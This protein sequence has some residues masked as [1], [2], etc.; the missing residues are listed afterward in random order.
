M[1]NHNTDEEEPADRAAE[2]TAKL[3]DVAAE[4]GLCRVHVLAWRD[5]DDAEAG[6]SEVHADRIASLWAEAG[7]DVLLRTSRAEGLAR[8]AARGGYRVAR[9]G[10]RLAA[11]PDAVIQE[12]LGRDG[13]R[14]AL[15]EVWNGMPYFSPLWARGPRVTFVHHVHAEMWRQALTP[16][17]ARLG[18]TIELRIAPRLYRGTRVLTGSASA[19]QTILDQ[20]GLAPDRVSIVPY[21]IGDGFSAAGP[22]SPTPLV[23]VAGRLVPHK[24]I[25]T[26][27]RTVVRLR[28]RHPDLELVVV[29]EGW[30]RPA[31]EAL[32]DELAA[33]RFVR[34]TGRV[35]DETLVGWYRRAWV[36]AS[37]STSEGWG[38]TITEAAGCETP[39]VVSR[40][41]GHVD[42]VLDGVTGM[43][44]DDAAGL[45]GALGR[46]IA[47]PAL[48]RRLG[49][50]A[51][52]HAAR[53]TWPRTALGVL[54]ALATEAHRRR[55]S[56]D[57]SGI[58]AP[59]GDADA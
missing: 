45:E 20:L 38:L 7:I 19:R 52:V 9:R 48:R 35:D 51:A 40:V 56:T 22:R 36:L 1:L 14:D 29:G 53:F 30:S 8:H 57:R 31:L 6:G 26:V 3:G 58:V 21:G 39:A 27:I 15:V 49:K 47:E 42:A 32:V 37:A 5:L 2:V 24:H 4:A 18:E 44:V 17:L 23:V 16:G 13:R 12:L 50:A 46:V 33:G 28:R 59:A 11:F 10:G 25:D 54:D 41:D 34:F 43:L 55:R